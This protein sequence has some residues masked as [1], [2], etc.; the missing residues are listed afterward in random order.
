MPGNYTLYFFMLVML[1]MGTVNMILLKFQHMQTAPMTPDGP[2]VPFDHPWLQAGL[3]M[4]GELLCLPIYLCTR[5]AEDV[6][7]AKKMPA[8]V[9]LLPCVCDL[10]ATALLCTGLAFVAVSVAQMCRGTVVIFVCAMS[11]V[12][13][14]RRQH[15][16]H[17]VGVALVAIGIGIVSSA[18][19]RLD[20]PDAEGVHKLAIGICVCVFAQI[21]QAAMFVCEEMIMS[22]Y[23]CQPLQVVGMEGLFGVGIS[24]VLLSLLHPLGYANTPG[25][26]HQMYSFPLL[27]V[28]VLGSMLAT[29]IFNFAGATV[30]KASSAV[31]RTTIKISSTILIWLVELSLGWNTFSLLQFIGFIFVASGTL[32]YNRIVIIPELESAPEA[33]VLKGTGLRQGS[34]MTKV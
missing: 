9:F 33:E 11:V 26:I 15:C 16:F 3:M 34:R 21:F 29:A 10:I 17:I 4:V 14:G 8:R 19:L 23:V 2:A 6:E 13:L 7:R 28:S 12:F 30:T 1:V 5:T 25:A 32:L 27:F 31:S 22:R 20:S 18:A 24:A